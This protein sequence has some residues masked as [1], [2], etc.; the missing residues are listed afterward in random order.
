MKKVAVIGAGLGG[1]SA[2]IHLAVKGFRV[3][4]FERTDRAGG[5]AGIVET[6]G[7]RFD[8][9]PSLV[10]MPFVLEELFLA[11]G[12]RLEDELTLLPIEPVC[13][14]FFRDGSR[15][16]AFAD[17]KAMDDSLAQFAPGD[18]ESYKR[19][20]E[21]S[22][23][24]YDLTADLFLFNSPSDI[25]N[26]FKGSS[27]RALLHLPKVDAFRTV[28]TAVS[29]FFKDPRLVQVFDRYATYN[30]SDPFKAPAT[31]NIIPWVEYGIGGFYVKGGIYRLVRVLT[32]MANQTGVKFRYGADVTRINIAGGNTTGITLS[33]GETVVTDAVVSNSDSV[34]TLTRLLPHSHRL[35]KYRSMEPSCSGMVFLW[36]VK[37]EQK[38]LR[39]H[40]IFF[41]GDYRGEFTQIFD[42]RIAPEDPTVYV[43]VTSK[44]DP[45]HAP[46]GHENWFVLVNM[47]YLPD[48]GS[49]IQGEG[50]IRTRIL[51]R[52]GR[53][54]IELEGRIVSETTIKP[55]DF[56]RRFRSNRGSIYGLSSN[57]K[58]SAFLRPQNRIKEVA[59]L[60]LCGG[61]AHPGGG[62]PLV[63]LSGRHAATVCAEDLTS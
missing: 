55:E 52:L 22:R 63:L 33:N 57:S 16:D 10:T 61:S 51:E 41:S 29:S 19:F 30:G 62:I 45:D 13:R 20:L 48:D 3:E 40:N 1:I 31:L 59:G 11:A 56:L 53:A 32:D 6:G 26:Y 18:R 35:S 46:P 23:T 39:H 27:L 38:E 58:M 54:G 21:Y 2:A 17:R 5:K 8:T 4:V 49:A 36:G 50:M 60:Y 43:S 24:I 9:G 12:K 37:G 44:T 47:P 15:F 28:H 7:F 25:R 34:E 14:Y 42:K